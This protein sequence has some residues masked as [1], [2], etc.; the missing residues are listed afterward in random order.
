MP[1]L[2]AWM[3]FGCPVYVLDNAL[4]NTTRII[5]KWKHRGRVGVYL[6]R[7]PPFM[8]Q[9]LLWF[10]VFRLDV[11]LPSFMFSLI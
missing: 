2:M 7:P 5:N 1:N 11:S 8:W 9:Q 10:T 6:G 4:Q 3:P